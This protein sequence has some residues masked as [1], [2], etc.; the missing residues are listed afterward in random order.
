VLIPLARVDEPEVDFGSVRIN[1]TGMQQLIVLN[2]GA[3]PLAVAVTN[4]GDPAFA[5][6]M[7]T[8]CIGAGMMGQI[9]VTFAPT[10]LGSFR[11]EVRVHS[12][13]ASNN[14][15]R[16]TLNGIGAM[17]T[18]PPVRTDGGTRTDGGARTDGGREVF[19][20]QVDAGCA[21]RTSGPTQAPRGAWIVALGVAGA[22]VAR[23]R[24][25][26]AA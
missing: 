9:P 21:C 23:R 26:V 14:P 1:T 20:P 25:R 17:E 18:V 10:S 22:L 3:S 24:R 19:G 13:G 4:P 5:L 16:V 7:N 12:N 8:T 6:G 11:S 2:P 15:A